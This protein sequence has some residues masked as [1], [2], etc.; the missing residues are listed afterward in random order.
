MALGYSKGYSPSVLSVESGDLGAPVCASRGP[1]LPKAECRESSPQG[2]CHGN[3]KP[4]RVVLPAEGGSWLLVGGGLGSACDACHRALTPLVPPTPQEACVNIREWRKRLPPG[5]GARGVRPLA[6]GKAR[7]PPHP[8]A[9]PRLRASRGQRWQL[10]SLMPQRPTSARG[11]PESPCVLSRACSGWAARPG[12]LPQAPAS[13][14]HL[15]CAPGPA[16]SPL[17]A[18]DAAICVCNEGGLGPPTP[19]CPGSL[20]SGP[21]SP[22]GLGAVTPTAS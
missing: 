1:S 8:Q 11:S 3:E 17:G 2:R 16:S 10:S 13:Q 6:G 18:A 7:E 14:L 22:A 4:E 19:G 9:Q 20:L 21:P 5:A 12:R 15:L